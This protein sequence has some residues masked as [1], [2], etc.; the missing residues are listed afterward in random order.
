[1]LAILVLIVLTSSA[2]VESGHL[3]PHPRWARSFHRFTG[4]AGIEAMRAKATR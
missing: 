3:V 2:P 1:L 4:G